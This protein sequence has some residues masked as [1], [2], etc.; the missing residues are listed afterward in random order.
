VVN[1]RNLKV[2]FVMHASAT[3][4]NTR[5]EVD[6]ASLRGVWRSRGYGHLL[7]IHNNG[8]TL[9]E[10]TAVSCLPVFEGTL[11]E[12]AAYYVDLHVSPQGQAFSARRAAGVSRVSFRRSTELP[13]VTDPDDA[14][15]DPVRNF[16]IFWH[17]FAEHYALFD[18][19]AIDW[20]A[21]YEEHRSAVDEDTRPRQLFD[22]FTDMLQP[23]G[24]GHVQLHTTCGHFDAGAAVPLHDRLAAELDFADDTRDVPSYLAELREWM[25]DMIREDYLQSS[26]R[27]AS[28]RL[29]WGAIDETTGYLAIRA[30]AGLCGKVGKPRDDMKA[31][32]EAMGRVMDELGAMDTLIVDVRGNGGGY[33]AVALRLAGYLT[34]RKRLAFTK[35]ARRGESFTGQQPIHVHPAGMRYAGRIILLTSGLTAS[36]AEIFVLALLQHPRVTRLGEPTHG[37]LSDAMERHLPNGWFMTL[38]NEIYRAADGELYEDRGIPPHIESP[39]LDQAGRDDGRDTTLDHAIELAHEVE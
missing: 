34:D 32:D 8:Y 5:G 11:D 26:H 20:H 10:E 12:L 36:A 28:R 39:F 15:Y 25:R 37:I 29:E 2:L 16:D 27:A 4:R 1:Q 35:S 18:L 38:S 24:D 3:H 6:F 31:V 17:T 9:Y 33:D 19:K 7:H 21:V 13:A 14:R 23:L 30:M 22:V